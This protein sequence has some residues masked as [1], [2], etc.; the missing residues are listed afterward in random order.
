M[1]T[2]KKLFLI[3]I[4]AIIPVIGFAA[5]FPN[6]KEGDYVIKNFKFNDGST[7]DNLKIHYTTIG[8][9]DG[10]PVLILHGTTGNGK[11]MLNESFGNALFDKGMPLDA[12]KYFIILPDSIGTGG[13][14]KPSDGLQGNFP[15]YDYTDM[16]N[17]QYE[18]LKNGLGIEHLTL[19][20]GNS[21]GGMNTWKWVT[22]YPDYMTAAVPMAATP[23]PMSSR[24]WIMRKMVINAIRNDP[25][26]NNGFYTQQPE[27]FQTVYNY[28][29]IATNGGDIA[30]QN[31]AY[32]TEITEEILN[33]RL[34][35][36]VVM[37]TND[38]L[39]QW[40]AARTFDPS[41]DLMKIKAFVLAINSADDERNPP[42][43]QLMEKAIEKIPHAKY[44]L[45]P[46]SDKTSGHSTTMTADLWKGQLTQ[47]L[48][49]I[50]SND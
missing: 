24:N 17:A 20:I 3:I 15:H 38:F 46:A 18:L 48:N 32:N 44:Y 5:D 29:N 16:V 31:Q 49:E 4:L 33:K 27:A 41:N 30:W 22:M 25:Q 34:Q 13:S 11:S 50:S 19:I 21:M 36:R 2:I 47:F 26:W 28:Y 39:Y 7:I 10:Q 9:P 1:A 6:M 23:A 45:I 35:N 40:D 12:E 42:T 43:T 14:S 37:D 8:N